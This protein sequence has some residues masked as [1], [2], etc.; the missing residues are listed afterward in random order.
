[1]HVAILGLGPSLSA[2]VDIAKR[3]GSR[4][5]LCDEVWGINAVG[6]V[7]ECDRVFHMD[8]VRI[9]EI[10]AAA[11]PDSN[12]AAMLEWLKGRRPSDGPVYTSIPKKGYP[13]LVAFPLEDVI[14]DLGYAY[15]NGTAAYAAALAIHI[16]ARK[17]SLFGCDYSYPNAH[18]AERGRGCLEYWLGFARA[19]GIEI[20]VAG[21][22]SLLDAC[23]SDDERLYGY[24]TVSVAIEAPED[25]P[26]RVSFT[27][28]D[29]LPSAD[30]IE[31]RYDHSR[32]PSP[33]ISGR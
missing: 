9:Q 2:Y 33:L 31:R 13:G 11:R 29:R 26:A 6:S 4:R 23:V 20:M 21:S 5:R 25:G 16:G 14:N 17:I 30:E 22:S 24:D 3:L 27:A 15:F 32:H 19:R 18:D 7:I 10:R 1:M 12:I 8:D 28:R